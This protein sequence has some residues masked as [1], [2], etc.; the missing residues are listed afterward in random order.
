MLSSITNECTKT[1][2]NLNLINF[3]IKNKERKIGDCLGI[4]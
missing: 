1:N 2:K 3:K 4:K